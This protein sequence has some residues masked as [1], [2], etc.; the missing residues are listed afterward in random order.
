MPEYKPSGYHTVTPYLVVDGAE[1]LIAFIVDVLGGTESMRLPGP[2]G[3]IGHAEIRVGDSVLMLADAPSP[4]EITMAML[5]VYV[6][7]SDATYARAM[8][9]GATSLREPQNEFYGDRM[10]GI[11]D[12]MGNKWY[13]ATHF[14]DVSDDEMA[15]RADDAA[16]HAASASS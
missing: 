14:E 8:A 11:Q 15:R 7:D 5:H 12:A 6:P 2:D 9:A 13:F 1:R 4:E 3:R 16:D 10:S